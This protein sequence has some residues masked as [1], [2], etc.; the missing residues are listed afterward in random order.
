V[1]AE[2]DARAPELVRRM[3]GALGHRGPDDR[4]VWSDPAGTAVLGTCRLSILDLSPAGHQ[5]MA[6]PDGSLVVA[7]NGEVYNYRELRAELEASGVE[8]VSGT[9]TEVVLKAW[10]RWGEAALERFNGMFAFFVLDRSSGR[11]YLVRDRFGIKPCLYHLAS[12]RLYFAS[13]AKAFYRLPGEV[14]EPR[15]DPEALASLLAFQ[16]LDSPGGTVLENLS[17]LPP[18]HFLEYDPSAGTCRL[19]RYYRLESEPRAPGDRPSA[20]AAGRELL[21]SSVNLRL[22]SDVP[23]G[24]L[25][26]G[27][28]DSS[29]VAALAARG[30]PGKIKTF[31]AGFLHRLDER[32]Y[33]RA[34]AET[35]GSEHHEVVLDPGELC[36][37]IEEVIPAFDALTSLD[38][39]IFTIWFILEKLKEHRV[40]V[41]LVGEGADEVFGGYSWFRLSRPPFSILPLPLR[42][43]LHHYAVSRMFRGAAASAGRMRAKIEAYRDPDIFRQISRW[44][45][46]EQL[47]SNYLMKVDHATMAH[48]VEARVP[49]LDHRLVEFAFGL[50]PSWKMSPGSGGE[51]AFLRALAEGLLPP[52]IASR[53]KL[54][55]PLSMAEVLKS[56]RRKVLDYLL[57]PDSFAREHYSRERIEALADFRPRRY[58]PL[59]KEKEFLLWKLFLIEAWRR[60]LLGFRREASNRDV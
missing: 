35:I 37:R 51:K 27:G 24:I 7:Y 5:P 52:R 4:G 34:V 53:P 16:F 36:R 3:L 42:S 1:G 44:E 26:S 23:V 55:F 49:Y 8:F 43:R 33:A 6:T 59:E 11:G 50:P 20:L 41:M 29:L 48:S 56:N 2:P 32:P 10:E 58:S 46:E 19:R 38:A 40:K 12:G 9:D 45:I 21:E 39:G 47:P 30:H 22:R 28:L 14:W 54:G 17:R 57:A 13:E 25:L 31:T 15:E 18:G 60:W